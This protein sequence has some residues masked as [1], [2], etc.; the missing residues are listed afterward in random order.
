MRTDFQTVPEQLAQTMSRIYRLGM[1]TTSGGNLSALDAKGT[2]WVTP[3]RLDKAKLQAEDM[4]SVDSAGVSSGANRATSE[5]PFHL[6]IYDA[7]PDIRAVVHAHPAALVAFSAAGRVPDTRVLQ[8][9]YQQCGEVGL[10]PYAL[11]GSE[12]LGTSIAEQFA[13]GL[14]CVVMDH[15]GVVVGGRTLNEAFARFELLE[16]T[17]QTLLN[18]AVLGKPRTLSAKELAMSR[19]AG[20]GAVVT[21]SESPVE[22]LGELRS[23]LCEY[24]HRGCERRLF[25]STSGAFSARTKQQS[26]L[27][28]PDQIDHY[29]LESNDLL[30]LPTK[31]AVPGNCWGH[32]SQLHREFYERHPEVNAIVHALPVYASAFSITGTEIQSAV[33]PESYTVLREIQDCPFEL[34]STDPGKL[35][36]QVSMRTPVMMIQNHGVLI[37]GTSVVDVYDRLE[38]LESAA[39][40]ILD[41][42]ALGPLQ[43]MPEETLQQLRAALPD[44]YGAISKGTQEG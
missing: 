5:L 35:A 4:V 22:S 16:L 19:H 44:A 13:K 8:Q 12:L 28:T 1:T 42:H 36:E 43:I 9:V 23:Q 6:A 38:V 7:R 3:A 14:D 30:E 31:P 18:A 17:A 10:A 15:H 40:A 20:P 33:I 41:C 32:Q 29:L 11:P 34:P 37:V 26:F 2:L 27:M 39:Q 24:V 25:S 21:E